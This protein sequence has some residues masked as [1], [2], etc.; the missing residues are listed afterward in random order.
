VGRGEPEK[1]EQVPKIYSLTIDGK[2]QEEC[3]FPAWI[4][5]PPPEDP[6]WSLSLPSGPLPD[7]GSELGGLGSGF[8]IGMETPI[9][10]FEK[11]LGRLPFPDALLHFDRVMA[12]SDPAKKL[13]ENIDAEAFEF[14]EAVTQLHDGSEGPRYWLAD[15]TRFLDAVDEERSKEIYVEEKIIP[16]NG[17]RMRR[18]H[19][20]MGPSTVFKSDVVNGNHI[21]RATYSGDILFDESV[22]GA[23][24]AAKLRGILPWPTGVTNAG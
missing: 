10:V 12:L 22:A 9:L 1:V 19:L 20:G 2:V 21:F 16:R 15:V 7:P 4:N 11:P 18:V 5:K 14:R 23:I 3:E 17:R 6:N 8:P 24:R 13:F